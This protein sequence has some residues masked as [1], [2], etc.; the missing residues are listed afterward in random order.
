[1]KEYITIDFLE[2]DITVKSGSGSP[3]HTTAK[4][5]NY[6]L[7]V[8]KFKCQPLYYIHFGTNTTEKGINHLYTP[9]AIG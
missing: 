6:S 4:L 9:P 1:M 5:L 8:N 7:Q 3:Q 2:K